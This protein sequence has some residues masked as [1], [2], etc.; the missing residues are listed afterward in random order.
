MSPGKGLGRRQADKKRSN[1]TRTIGDG[2]RCDLLL[3]NP[4]FCQGLLNAN[5]NDLHMVATGHFRHHSAKALVALNLAGND[6]AQ[7]LSLILQNRHTGLVTRRL[8]S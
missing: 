7:K 2:H 6:I 1:Q 8:K 5:R 4:C 3:T